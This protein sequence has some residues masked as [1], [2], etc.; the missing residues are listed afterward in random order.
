MGGHG[1]DAETNLFGYEGPPTIQE[2][3][4]R[5]DKELEHVSQQMATLEK[6]MVYKVYLTEIV[7]T[8]RGS[9][10][11]KIVETIRMLTFRYSLYV[12]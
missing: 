11:E 10:V 12:Q 7:D 1:V 9:F 8:E 3:R 5:L 2:K 6:K 4:T